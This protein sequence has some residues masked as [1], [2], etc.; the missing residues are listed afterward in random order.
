MGAGCASLIF[1]TDPSHYTRKQHKTTFAEEEI[2]ER[3][4]AAL[5]ETK[6]KKVEKS[7]ESNTFPFR[8]CTHSE[9]FAKAKTVDGHDRFALSATT[10]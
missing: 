4:K 2:K 8:F 3:T 5:K 10:E 9:A 1:R 6:G 7:Q